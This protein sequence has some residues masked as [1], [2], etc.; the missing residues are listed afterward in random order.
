MWTILFIF[1]ATNNVLKIKNI[2]NQQNY[3]NNNTGINEKFHPKEFINFKTLN[4]LSIN[5][6]KKN[7]LDLLMNSLIGMEEKLEIIKK[8]R[9]FDD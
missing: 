8:N 6:N 3:N 7:N 5:T 9:Y 2:N 1:F 4:E